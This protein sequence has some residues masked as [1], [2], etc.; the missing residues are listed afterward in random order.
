MLS[1]GY[2]LLC[3]RYGLAKIIRP[4][5]NTANV[6]VKIESGLG[7]K[8][9]QVRVQVQVQQMDLSPDSS[10]TSLPAPFNAERPNSAW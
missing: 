9:A 5:Q 4:K 1:N 8:S 2:L 3:V 10:T 7:Y 6:T